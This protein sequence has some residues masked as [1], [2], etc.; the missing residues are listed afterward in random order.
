MTPLAIAS[1]SNRKHLVN[2]LLSVPGVDVNKK[3]SVVS[4]RDIR[5]FEFQ[6]IDM[7]VP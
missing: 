4:G 6:L 5:L 3:D 2:I 7:R 1:S